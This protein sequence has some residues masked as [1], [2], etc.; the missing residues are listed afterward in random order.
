MF[1]KIGI[2][3]H[4]VNME[5]LTNQTIGKVDYRLG[6]GEFAVIIDEYTLESLSDMR[7]FI[8]DIRGVSCGFHWKGTS[9]SLSEAMHATDLKMY[10]VKAT[11]KGK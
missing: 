1:V 7:Q 9:E 5:I 3:L 8:Q 4:A 11:K 10:A 2:L 6:G